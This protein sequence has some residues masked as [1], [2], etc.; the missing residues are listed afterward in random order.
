MFFGIQGVVFGPI[1]MAAVIV[2]VKVFKSAVS[3]PS[4]EQVDSR[5]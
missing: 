5:T 2:A 1:C 4:S 3:S